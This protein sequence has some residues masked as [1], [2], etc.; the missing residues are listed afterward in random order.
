MTTLAVTIETRSP[1]EIASIYWQ[2]SRP[3]KPTS[4][5][6]IDPLGVRVSAL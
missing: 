5:R 1:G 4:L 6:A 3:V 2:R